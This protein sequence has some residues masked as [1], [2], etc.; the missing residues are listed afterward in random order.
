MGW[1]EIVDCRASYEVSF[2]ADQVKPIIP[3]IVNRKM[4]EMEEVA[5]LI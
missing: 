1:H 5:S 4:L 3:A 2:L